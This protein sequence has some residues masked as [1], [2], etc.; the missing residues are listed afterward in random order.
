MLSPISKVEKRLSKA[1]KG[2]NATSGSVHPFSQQT[3]PDQHQR[4]VA[5]GKRADVPSSEK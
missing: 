1:R 4:G 3:G 5:V 2:R